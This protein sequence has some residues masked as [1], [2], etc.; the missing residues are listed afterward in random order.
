MT[1]P[2]ESLPA[3][4]ESLT[5]KSE[6]RR[7]AV[8][9]CRKFMKKSDDYRRPFLELA[10][11][12]RDSYN[13]WNLQSKSITQRANLNLPYAY[14][15]VQ[16]ELPQLA[17]ICLKDKPYFR[18]KGRNQ[19]DF[20][21]EDS[22]NDFHAMQLD[23]MRFPPKFVSFLTGMLI[24]GTAVAKV[25]YR[26]KEQVVT[27]REQQ[28]DPMLGISYPTKHREVQVEFD[29]PDFETIRI[30]DFFP[31]WAA[32][33]PGDIE[34]QRGCVHRLFKTFSELKSMEKKSDGGG[35]YENL[36][37]LEHSVNKKGC[38]A[39]AD[40]Y[41]KG[42]YDRYNGNPRED[43][44]RKPVEIW[45]YWGLFDP[46]GD[47]T[48]IEYVV[49]IANGDVVIRMEENFYDQKFRPFVACVNSV[50]DNEF[51]GVSEIFAVRPLIKE[52][53]A[54]RNARLDQVNLAVNRMWIVDRAA[55]INAKTLYSRPGGIIYSNDVNGLR[56]L[57][58]PEVPPSAYRE[59]QEIQGEIQTTTGNSSGP[60]LSEAGRVFGR[61]AT[62]ANLVSN[63]AASRVGLKALLLSEIFFKR[64]CD[65]V[66]M[67][68]AQF[69][70][71][72]QWVKSSDPN[73]PNPFVQLPQ[74]AFHCEY[75]FERGTSL[76]M[77]PSQD[78]QKLQTALQ[79]FQIAESTQP[80]TIDWGAYFK[81]FGRDL[82]GRD[83][84]R[85]IR[86][87]ADRMAMQQQ[88]AFQQEQAAAQAQAQ[89]AAQGAAAPQPNSVGRPQ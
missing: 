57:P 52:A 86:S 65:V 71:D 75:D 16:S 8:D 89:A 49:T 59:I 21:F 61:S 88:M 15:I 68:N 81:Q 39:W 31:D 4:E 37:E 72:D 80:G 60:S 46:K 1:D 36:T 73:S 2:F 50:L 70:T 54:L 48:F 69:V 3:D 28:T 42:D 25:P 29:G 35:I 33:S 66:L 56:E 30:S 24:D 18:V 6:Q 20:A 83:V 76:D 79:L 9:T 14:Q 58:P 27:V 63:I 22:L 5:S 47:G 43:L 64:M 77:D 26:Y 41:F 67:T 13:C 74:E 55:G 78:M 84:K 12:A 45:E 51:Y 85:F 17:N 10:E 44:K 11:K 62:G 87:D 38:D 34:G 7:H 23:A 82:F 40:P 53:S 19:K 32:K